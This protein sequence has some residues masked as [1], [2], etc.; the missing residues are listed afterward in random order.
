MLD[1]I[2]DILF[3]IFMSIPRGITNYINDT[4]WPWNGKAYWLIY[5]LVTLTWL[6]VGVIAFLIVYSLLYPLLGY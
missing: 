1:W 2:G 3:S 6:A 5:G 4:W